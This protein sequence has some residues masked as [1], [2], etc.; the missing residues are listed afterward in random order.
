MRTNDLLCARLLPRPAVY[1]GYSPLNDA[2]EPRTLDVSHCFRVKRRLRVGYLENGVHALVV[3][4]S[5]PHSFPVLV[6]P[7]GSTRGVF[8]RLKKGLTQ[9]GPDIVDSQDS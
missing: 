1:L 4:C 5:S 3:S 7:S 9:S 6:A 8:L 2:H